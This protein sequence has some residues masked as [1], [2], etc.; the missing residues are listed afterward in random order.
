MRRYLLAGIAGFWL[1]AGCNAA[2]APASP[3]A[4]D[5]PPDVQAA[6]AVSPTATREPAHDFTLA[7][8]DGGSVTLAQQ[9]GRMRDRVATLEATLKVAGEALEELRST[10]ITREEVETADAALQR[11][12]EAQ[13]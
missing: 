3:I 2:G 10:A 9:V 7:T 8:L 4:A 13:R 1:V 11:I 12:K 5:S 6:T